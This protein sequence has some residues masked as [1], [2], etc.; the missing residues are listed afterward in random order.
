MKKPALLLI[1]SL[2]LLIPLF[3]KG[4]T[5]SLFNID[6]ELE[7]FPRIELSDGDEE[8]YGAMDFYLVTGGPGSLV[9]ENFGHTA[10]LMVSP[11]SFP[12]AYDWGIFSFDE[13]FFAN[14]AFGRLYYEAWATYGEYR[15]KVLEE[16]DRSV[17]ILKMELTTREK[18][19]M[20]SFLSYA[21]REENRT[22]LYDYFRDNCATRPR[23]IYSWATG[24]EFEEVLKGETAPESIR[25][26]VE[27]H[28]SLSSFP[29]AWTISYLLGP[30]VDGKCTL[31]DACFLPSTLEKEI[32]R[33]QGNQKTT[34]YES[35]DRDTVPQKW[36]M[37][38]PSFLMGLIL[39]L[40][41][42]LFLTGKRWAERIGDA[43]LGLVY[44]YF[45]ILSLVLI[46]F[47]AFT[48]HKVTYG[49]INVLIISPLCLAASVLH[50]SSLGKKRREKW[51]GINLMVMV[52][53]L[54]LSVI[55][56]FFPAFSVQDS[57][58]VYIP[59]AMLY[60]SEGAAS[61]I[62]RKRA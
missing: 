17:G 12:V 31:W 16:D 58:S 37:K 60:L 38:V 36:N 39:F 5:P 20:A 8:Y 56:R 50:F 30:S 46:F 6:K 48:I 18:K 7:E 51:M 15:I 52:F 4:E 33:Y 10:I 29:V 54:L 1:L 27:R 21:T 62:R 42:I 45:A 35:K 53:L 25:E 57:L 2:A 13:S 19:E 26:T 44:L 34:Y 59:A 3:S 24:G 49:N 55:L 47:M 9:W 32:Q 22:Y 14:F 28:L 11:S 43:A 40:I 61:L 41:P 23:D